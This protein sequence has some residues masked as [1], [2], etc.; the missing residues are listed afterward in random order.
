MKELTCLGL[1][2]RLR[3]QA[4]GAE[5]EEAGEYAEYGY[6]L[7]FCTLGE[8]A[9]LDDPLEAVDIADGAAR[10]RAWILP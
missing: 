6:V 10:C 8:L 5:G 3:V 9:S 4:A 7:D 2:E 1:A